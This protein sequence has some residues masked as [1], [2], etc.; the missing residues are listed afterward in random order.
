MGQGIAFGS[1]RQRC[2]L[3]A[4]RR[5]ASSG[6]D[7]GGSFAQAR[8]HVRPYFGFAEACRGGLPGC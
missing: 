7:G 6:T 8:N 5:R 1:Q 3:M 2:N 4:D